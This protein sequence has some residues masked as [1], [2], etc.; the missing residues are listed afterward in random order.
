MLYAPCA[1]GE[2]L[3]IEPYKLFFDEITVTSTYSSSPYDTKLAYDYLRTGRIRGPEL[4]THRFPMERAVDA[5]QMT[6]KPSDGLKAVV[7][8]QR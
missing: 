7:T 1:P 5:F 4:V 8:M 6:A 2:N 3:P